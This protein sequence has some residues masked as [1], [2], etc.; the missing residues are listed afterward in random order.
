MEL[1]KFA[2]Q[3]AGQEANSLRA[4]DL[5]GNFARLRPLQADGN[6]RQYSIE[7]T[8]LGWRLK[9]YPDSDSEE[10]VLS[11]EE[12]YEKNPVPLGAGLPD[13]P[14][15]GTFVLGSINGTIQWLAT[16]ACT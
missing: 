1:F 2:S 15:S 4:S 9:L 11:P 7:E 5:D 6:A 16:E 3:L 10:N 14:S 8:P 12:F 13:P